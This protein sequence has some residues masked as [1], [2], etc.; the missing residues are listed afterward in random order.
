MSS[1]FGANLDEVPGS[2]AI[3]ARRGEQPW[4]LVFLGLYWQR[5]GGDIALKAF[6]TLRKRG[7]NAEL[8][9]VGSQPPETI[10]QVHVRII[11]YLDKRRARDRATLREI[12]LSSHVMLFP[13]V[14][15]LLSNCTVRSSGVWDSRRRGRRRRYQHDCD[16]THRAAHAT[17]QHA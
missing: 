7:V 8:T 6:E 10:D 5:K 13:N 4:K 3:Y 1:P 14:R 2:D 12:L 15:R 16:R 17:L 11:P 9:I